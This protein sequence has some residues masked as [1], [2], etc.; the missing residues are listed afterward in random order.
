MAPSQWKGRDWAGCKIRRC[1][2]LPVATEAELSV[3]GMTRIIAHWDYYTIQPEY[4][5]DARASVLVNLTVGP[6]L[7]VGMGG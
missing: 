7:E 5:R 2:I 4:T 3:T 1:P 6:H